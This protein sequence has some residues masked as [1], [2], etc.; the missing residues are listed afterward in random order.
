MFDQTHFQQM[1]ITH[2]EDAKRI[3][4]RLPTQEQATN[5]G[6]KYFSGPN[7]ELANV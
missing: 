6:I 2:R 4:F 1:T 5:N 3:P 7:K